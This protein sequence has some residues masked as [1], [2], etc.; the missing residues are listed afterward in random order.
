MP[1][2]FFFETTETVTKNK[3]GYVLI[4]TDF[5]QVYDCFSNMAV[6]LKSATSMKLLFWLLAHEV[7]KNNG[8]SSSASVYEK[9]VKHLESKGGEG[10]T[11]R[12]FFRCFD[13]LENVKAITKVGR[14]HWYFNPHM[15]WRNEKNERIKFIQDETKE[16]RYISHNPIE[17]IEEK[18]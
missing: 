10:V 9:F 4:D 16:G 18:K 8:F 2:K 5:T 7:N 13:E 1:K 15:F 14:G 3:K 6:S 17:Q 12:T 11:E